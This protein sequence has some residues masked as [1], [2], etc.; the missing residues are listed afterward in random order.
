[1][2]TNFY[3]AKPLTKEQRKGIV[4]KAKEI[5]SFAE[6]STD[7]ELIK[8][9]PIN[10]LVEDLKASIPHPI[11]IG[12]RSYGWQFLWDYNDGRFFKPTLSNIKKFLQGK[13]IF[14]EYMDSFTLNH[15]LEDEIAS[16]LYHDD[17]HDDG[18]DGKEYSQYYFV[19]DGLRFSKFTDFR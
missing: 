14:D 17:N 7:I 19:S 2:G 6:K 12:K 11:H 4:D 8:Q 3:C 13:I 18:M 9:H 5:V 1:M 15:F 16:C 10:E